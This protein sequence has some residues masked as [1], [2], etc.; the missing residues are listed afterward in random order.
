MSINLYKL[1]LLLIIWAF[2]WGTVGLGLTWPVVLLI[3]GSILFLLW[4]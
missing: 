2:F 4:S 1:G 3:I